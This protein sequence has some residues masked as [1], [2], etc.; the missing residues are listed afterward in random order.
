[1]SA[2]ASPQA[3]AKLGSDLIL[4]QA[5]VDGRWISGSGEPILVEDP[6]EETR[7]GSVPSLSGEEVETA[8]EAAARAF[9]D[10]AARKGKAR[11]DILSR[12]AELVTANEEGLAA[13]ISLENGKPWKEALGEVR[14]ANSFITWFAGLAERLDGRRVNR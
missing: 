4:E 10:W 14:Y 13:L 3:L 5:L 12:W 1:M 9:P 2:Q 8:I 6:S 11:G 7:L